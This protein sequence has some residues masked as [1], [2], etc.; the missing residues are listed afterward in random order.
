MT[1]TT[2]GPIDPPPPWSGVD[3]YY[4]DAVVHAPIPVLVFAEDGTIM[5][6]SRTLLRLT[7]FSRRE[8]RHY[9]DWLELA[10]PDPDVQEQ[11]RREVRERFASGEPSQI[12]EREV[13]TSSGER[14]L[15][16]IAA[17]RPGRLS[18]GRR[19]L[20]VMAV[21]LTDQRRQERALR[22][23]ERRFRGTFENAA[24]GIAHVGVHGEWLEVNQRLCD[25]LGYSREE[26]LSSTF[27]DVTYP[28]DIDLELTLSRELLAGERT[29]YDVEKRYIHRD[30]RV[31][32]VHLTKALQ[33]RQDGRPL[34]CIAVVQDITD[35]RRAEQRIAAEDAVMD[36]LGSSKS[37]A[38]AAPRLLAALVRTLDGRLGELWLPDGDEL[39][40]S[41][42]SPADDPGA[43][44]WFEIAR[45]L[46]FRRGEGLPGSVWLSG[47][48]RWLEEIAA[49][50]DFR[51]RSEAVRMGLRTALAFPVL[52]ADTVLGVITLF[53]ER[54]RPLDAAMSESAIDIGR[55]IGQFVQRT[56]VEEALGESEERYRRLVGVMPA[57]VCTCDAAGRITFVNRRAVELW[58]REPRVGCDEERFCGSLRATRLDGSPL[59]RDETPMALA[60]RGGHHARGQELVVERPDGSNVVVSV[61]VDPLLDEQGRCVGAI[62]V[63]DDITE[64][65]RTEMQLREADRRKD[66]FL[67]VLGHEL[68]NPLAAIH[69]AVHL[70]E[71]TGE[72]EELQRLRELVGRQ[73]AQLA[74]LV[75]DLLDVTRISRGQVRVTP[76]PTD[77]FPVVRS[78]E[79]AV[80]ELMA[81][82]RHTLEIDLPRT[83]LGAR[84]DAARVEQVIV[85]L[86][87]NAAHY[88][89]P[90]G[91]IRLALARD[92]DDI[93][94]AV[95]DDGVGLSPADRE[96][97]F[98]LFARVELG[99]DVGGGTIGR[100]VGLGVGLALVREIVA[101]HGGDVTA[102]SEG[103]G[104]GSCFTVRLRGAA[105]DRPPEE[106]FAAPRPLA[107]R[108]AASSRRVLVVDDNRDLAANLQRLLVDAGH[109]VDLAHDAASAPAAA[110]RLGPE[111]ALVDIGLPD[112]SGFDVARQ[113]RREIAEPIFLVAITGF[114]QSRD[115]EL[116]EAAGFDRYLVKPL[117]PEQLLTLIAAAP[118]GGSIPSGPALGLDDEAGSP[119]SSPAGGEER[120]V[121]ILLVE[122]SP[123]VAQITREILGQLGYVVDHVSDGPAAL[124][125]ARRHA[126]DVVL[127]DLNL[128]GGMSGWEVA[129]VLREQAE[130]APPLLLAVSAHAAQDV[131]H[132]L[133]DSAFD[134]LHG[135]PL[136]LERLQQ[137][138]A[139][140]QEL[141]RSGGAR[142]LE[143]ARQAPGD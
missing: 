58:G 24:V 62:N 129:E 141:R 4:R 42:A 35:R 38:D 122:D 82:R 15:W 76:V 95:R 114:G 48:P 100:E 105:L 86:L 116:A 49:S 110:R 70:W 77:L 73:T 68:R 59:P 37:L 64:R 7:G 130:S 56:R 39:V 92:G 52:L 125:A 50:P 41:A 40:H 117:D 1:R 65:H 66:E 17:A 26:M 29:G 61:N 121:R 46:R 31:V 124:D 43:Q 47:R 55:G 75:D 25:M 123:A 127:C 104:R 109:V 21:D 119:V 107:A 57:G 32:W 44:E 67:A 83:P 45:T 132:R 16:S 85:N 112:A 69:S 78:A 5:A 106:L 102:E 133:R 137:A 108:P 97:I 54:P 99:H 34:Y 101:K 18:D 2:R 72:P 135:K 71:R 128:P 14:R 60:L 90:G 30:G 3:A 103:P 11:I 94:L 126:P 115:R 13:T 81:T 19:F 120:P 9:D 87:G 33:H 98:D 20:S 136:D 140:H 88:T 93:V 84:V 23:S 143:Q 27:Q 6:V 12:H 139:R 131:A 22:A 89:P 51:R 63:F 10:Y 74:R 111:V 36:V 113:L 53:F 96:R 142:P 134:D 28:D 79:A 138:V 91:N 118:A 80:S 8:L